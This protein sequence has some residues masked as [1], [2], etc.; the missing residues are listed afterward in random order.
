VLSWA[1]TTSLNYL[2]VIWKLLWPVGW[3]GLG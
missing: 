3:A 1:T 2:K